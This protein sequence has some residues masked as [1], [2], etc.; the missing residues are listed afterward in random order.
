[1]RKYVIS[2]LVVCSLVASSIT[3][4]AM[5]SRI[6]ASGFSTN[7]FS[8][9]TMIRGY[10]FI[11]STT[12]HYT[13]VRLSSSLGET[14]YS[15]RVWGTGRVEAYTEPLSYSSNVDYGGAVYYGFDK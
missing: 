9:N 5:D 6:T 12:S 2:A 14:I 8:N 7:I 11:T 4:F 3:A 10:G 13:S 15:E 1:M